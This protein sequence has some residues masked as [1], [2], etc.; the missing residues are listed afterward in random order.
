MSTARL[1]LKLDPVIK[2]K[3]E[4]ASALL[5][6][7]LTEYVVRLVDNDA[8]Q[9]IA[10]YESMKLENEVFDH[11]LSACLEAEAPNNALLEA[12]AFTKAQGIK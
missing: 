1:D 4:K 7:T 12:G 6:K 9:V 3:I 5:G 8:T 2:A 10:Q 11:F